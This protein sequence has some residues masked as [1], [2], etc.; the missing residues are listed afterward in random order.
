MTDIS[1]QTRPVEV[2]RRKLGTTIALPEG[3]DARAHARLLAVFDG[4]VARADRALLAV[5]G[6]NQP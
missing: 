5:E 6:A 1:H 3:A 2:A 4:D